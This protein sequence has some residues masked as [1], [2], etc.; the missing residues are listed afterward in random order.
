LPGRKSCWPA[1]SLCVLDI[2]FDLFFDPGGRP[3]GLP[4]GFL[5]C[6]GVEFGADTS[7]AGAVDGKIDLIRGIA[8][9]RLEISAMGCSD[10]S[11]CPREVGTMIAV[12]L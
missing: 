6:T 11:S 8:T 10:K 9:V 12:G 2:D 7:G 3:R 4:V 5:R 1:L